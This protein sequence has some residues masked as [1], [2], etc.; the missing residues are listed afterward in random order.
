MSDV[1]AGEDML[2]PV[3]M[4]VIGYPPEAPKT[5]E[6]LPIFIDLVDR[7]IISVL[8][9]RGLRRND[10]GTFDAFDVSDVDGIPD[11]A[12]LE[13]AETGLI[14]DEDVRAVVEAMEP[15]TA[16]LLIVFENRWAAPFV[17]AVYRNGGR[18]IAYERIGAQDLLDAL[19]ALES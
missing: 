13:G 11:A 19:A 3:D 18:L 10:D 15:G 14:A 12:V 5:G 9:V 4:V 8:D 1:S 17:N 2:G 7:G 16:A 6:A